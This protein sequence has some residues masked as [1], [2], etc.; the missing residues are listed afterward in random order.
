MLRGD[1]RSISLPSRMDGSEMLRAKGGRGVAAC[2]RRPGFQARPRQ[3]RT[4]LPERRAPRVPKAEKASG[5]L[6]EAFS[7]GDAP[8][9]AQNIYIYSRP[10]LRIALKTVCCIKVAI[11]IGP[12]PPGTG[13]Y[14]LE[15]GAAFSKSISPI[16]PA[17]YPA[18]TNTAPG[19]IQSA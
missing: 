18:S 8:P 15:R 7:F 3:A 16:L 6:P 4:R 2:G 11:V 1:A 12:T 17:L 10:A 5:I 13:V 9:C 19:F 14:A